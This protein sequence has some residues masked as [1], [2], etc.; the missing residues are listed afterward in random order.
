M[1]KASLV[2]KPLLCHACL[3]KGSVRLAWTVVSG[4]A[5]CIRCAIEQ[6]TDDDMTQH[7]LAASV[8]EELRQQ[9]HP[10]AYE[11]RHD[12]TICHGLRC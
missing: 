3:V 6:H 9:G 1:G 12:P 10:N 7:E 5:S 8:Y 11:K 4:D 2:G